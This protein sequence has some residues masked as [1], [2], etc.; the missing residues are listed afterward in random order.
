[1]RDAGSYQY[2]ADPELVHFFSGTQSHN[3]VMLNGLDQMEKGPR[4]VWLDWSQA[5]SATVDETEECFIF[6]GK[7]HAFKHLERNI[8]HRR[9]VI[10]Y[11]DRPHW[12]IEDQILHPNLFEMIQ[13]WNPAAEFFKSFKILAVDQKGNNI[14]PKEKSGWFS[15][16][17]G[18]KERTKQIHFRLHGNFIRTVITTPS[19]V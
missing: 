18:H 8:Y 15:N 1:L 7:I 12:I 19:T 16:S 4:F 6:E 9:K 14:E 2:N 3:T 5:I 10:K 13:I 17:Y 11:K